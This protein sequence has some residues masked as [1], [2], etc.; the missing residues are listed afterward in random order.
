MRHRPKRNTKIVATLGP[1]SSSREVIREMIFHGMN[2]ARLNFS[3]G[4]H[5]AHTEV[6]NLVR[7]EAAALDRHVAVFQDLC[8][9]KVRIS[10]LEGG[11]VTLTEGSQ[12]DLRYSGH[13]PAAVV[14]TSD[15]LY[16]EAFDP[17]EVMQPGEK[18]LLADGRIIL[19]VEEVFSDR[20]QCRVR[21]GGALRS[22]SGI[23]VPESKLDLPCLTEKDKFDLQWALKHQVDYVAL[24]FVGSAKDV[25]QIRAV[26]EESGE[27]LPV[28]AKIERAGSLDHISAIVEAADAVMVARGDL[29]LELPLERVPGAQRF[30][31]GAANYAGTPVITATQM[32][33][34]MVEE[35]RPTRAEVSDVCTAVR[36]GTDAVML[37]DETA[38]GKHPV[39]AV[40]VL[41]QIVEEAERELALERDRPPAKRSDREKVAD[42]VCYAA[43]NAADKIAAS[44][45]VACTQSGYTARLMS[46]YRPRQPLFGAT[47]EIRSL[48][49]MVL[50]WGVEPVY[51][52]LGDEVNIEDEVQSALQ[53]LRDMYGIK[54][55]SRVVIT[56][57]LRAKKKGSTNVMEIREVPRD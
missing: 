20:V 57:G 1:A 4:S 41:S 55:G 51:L 23:A 56:A 19:I 52:P 46:K 32:L 14:G 43:C 38:V 26:M 27:R 54:P 31:I 16:V 15:T 22:R 49:R 37:S 47:S 24:S 35:I 45:M 6:L 36:D 9:P 11:T 18:A 42:A 39:Q 2:V 44:A 50:Y 25:R 7:E 34:S 8:G 29:G 17:A 5:D 48:N 10:Q 21:A 53:A 33:M 40:H 3:H 12:V 13:D 28:I 30:I